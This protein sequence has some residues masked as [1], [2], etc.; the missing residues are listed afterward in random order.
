MYADDTTLSSNF[1]SFGN[2]IETKESLMNAELSNVFEWLNI[3]KLSL[4]K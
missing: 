4:N 2:D 1:A 3:D